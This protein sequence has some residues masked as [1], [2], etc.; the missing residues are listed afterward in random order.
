[1]HQTNQRKWTTLLFGCYREKLDILGSNEE[2]YWF[3]RTWIQWH[4]PITSVYGQTDRCLAT[5]PEA[6]LMTTCTIDNSVL[7]HIEWQWLPRCPVIDP[8]SVL[9]CCICNTWP[10]VSWPNP[11]INQS[12][13]NHGLI[14]HWHCELTMW[15]RYQQDS[16]PV[17]PAPLRWLLIVTTNWQNN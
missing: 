5:A 11:P 17:L 16:N 4:S 13:I 15:I 10:V 12:K 6:L 7:I 3:G 9:M 2:H 1:M 8:T 14:H